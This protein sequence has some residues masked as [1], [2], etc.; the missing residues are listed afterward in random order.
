[1]VRHQQQQAQ[2]QVD[3]IRINSLYGR[4]VT[5]MT[6]LM[7]RASDMCVNSLYGRYVTR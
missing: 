5:R 1:M 6:F 7:Q 2:A 4:Y 3:F